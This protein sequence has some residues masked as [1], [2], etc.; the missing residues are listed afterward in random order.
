MRKEETDRSP[1]AAPIP[2]HDGENTT[3]DPTTG[4]KTTRIEVPNGD[5]ASELD[6]ELQN[7]MRTLG[8]VVEHKSSTLSGRDIDQL[9]ESIALRMRQLTPKGGF[10]FL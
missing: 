7:S 5:E 2:S 9:Q 4:P 1:S 6:N 10:Q 3:F 8:S